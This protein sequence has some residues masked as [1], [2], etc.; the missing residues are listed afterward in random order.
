MP[1][2]LPRI[3]CLHKSIPE[4]RQAASVLQELFEGLL[5]IHM[6]IKVKGKPRLKKKKNLCLPSEA[7][8]SEGLNSVSYKE[9]EINFL[10]PLIMAPN[11]T[12]RRYSSKLQFSWTTLL[13]Y[14]QHYYFKYFKNRISLK[15]TY[16]LLHYFLFC[17]HI[18]ISDNHYLQTD[19][20]STP[21][22]WDSLNMTPSFIKL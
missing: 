4:E 10:E 13:S 3:F 22:N 15:N 2:L 16:Y 5:T 12:E 7:S 21:N 6:A 17:S 1:P 9:L 8:I 18:N 19:V 14:S 20:N 11:L